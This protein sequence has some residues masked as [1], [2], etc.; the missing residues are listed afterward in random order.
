ML[1]QL[2][3]DSLFANLKKYF[4]HQNKVRIFNYIISTYELRLED[5]K[6]KFIKK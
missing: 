5:K 3:K 1:D 2:K 4:Y 6:I